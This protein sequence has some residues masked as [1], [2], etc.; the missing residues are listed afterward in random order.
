MSPTLAHACACGC[1]VFDVGTASLFPDGSGETFFVEDDYMNQTQN[2]SGTSKAPAANNDD[3]QI[4]SEF[5]KVGFQHMFSRDW[6]IMVDAPI[7]D[8]MVRTDVG[9]GNVQSFRH[10]AFG[11]LRISGVY[12]GFSEDMS[13]GVTFG[14]KLPTGDWKYAGFDRDTAIGSGSTDLLLGAYHLG[15]LGKTGVFSYFTQVAWQ[16]PMAYQGGYRPGMEID[17]SV[18][19]YYR[20]WSLGDQ[21]MKLTPILQ[22]IGS[23]R[24]RDHGPAADTPNSGYERVLVTPGLELD[25]KSWRLYGD[26]EL[27]VYQ[28]VNGNQLVAPALFKLTLSRNF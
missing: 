24:A 27:P 1:G 18:G 8:R 26:V 16:Q 9:G 19:V 21:G 13:T 3:K 5:V 17:A 10:T 22:A 7:T 14:V 25:A 2:L 28:R 6:G 15:H 4:Q 23:D 20:G 11:D 12:S